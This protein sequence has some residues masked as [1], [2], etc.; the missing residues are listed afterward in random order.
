MAKSGHNAKILFAGEATNLVDETFILVPNTD[1]EVWQVANRDRDVL[2]PDAV[3]VVE[4][5]DDGGGTWNTI[6]PEEFALHYLTGCVD[7]SGYAGIGSI[8][9]VRVSGRYL[10]KFEEAEAYSS[11]IEKLMNLVESSAYQHQG[12]R[13]T[14]NRQDFTATVDTYSIG[15][16]PI[17]GDSGDNLLD[18][19]G[20]GTAMVFIIELDEESEI[21][22]WVRIGS[23][24]QDSPGDGLHQNSISLSGSQRTAVMAT[25]RV[26]LW[27]YQ[28][29]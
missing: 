28:T 6:P 9:D 14:P 13:R 18:L 12:V 16:K 26:S 24:N 10:P 5:S 11:G 15:T 2:D 19:A 17:D 8:T 1:G 29:A 3:F 20:T 27:D 7:L 21:R 22:A 25:Q 23:M 4:V